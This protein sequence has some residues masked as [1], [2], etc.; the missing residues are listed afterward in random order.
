[1]F[2][3][4]NDFDFIITEDEIYI[5]RINGFEKFAHLEEIIL[6]K[7]SESTERLGMI[8]PFL[9][10]ERLKKYASKHPSGARLI[11][12]IMARDDLAQTDERFLKAQ[13]KDKGVVIE[14]IDGK[15]APSRANESKLLHLLDRRMF[16]IRLVK[17]KK[18]TYQ[19]GSRELVQ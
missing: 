6:E 11:A 16:T 14:L 19:A 9:N 12:S 7:A 8:I 15:I 18:E 4:D 5:F 17:N 2:K 10:I 1:L 3:I 13:C